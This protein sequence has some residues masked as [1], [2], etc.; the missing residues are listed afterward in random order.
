MKGNHKSIK[1]F[2]KPKQKGERK[3]LEE[4]EETKKGISKE[5]EKTK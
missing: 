1:G 5:A 3:R 2:F 4:A